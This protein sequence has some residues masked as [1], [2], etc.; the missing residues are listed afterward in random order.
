MII[1]HSRLL[2]GGHPV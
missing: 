1:S 2:F